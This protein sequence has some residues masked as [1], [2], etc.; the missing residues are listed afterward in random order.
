[1]AAA[2]QAAEQK[3]QK[4]AAYDPGGI[5]SAHGL[6]WLFK[7]TDIPPNVKHRFYAWSNMKHLRLSNLQSIK[8]VNIILAQLDYDIS[9]YIK[10]K[11]RKKGEKLTER[12]LSWLNQLKA[13]VRLNL[14]ASLGESRDME[15]ITKSRGEWKQEVEQKAPPREE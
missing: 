4:E 9:L 5:G 2:G 15:L 8:N 6:E 13:V 14:M 11:K 3:A 12:I 7:R 1:M 10:G